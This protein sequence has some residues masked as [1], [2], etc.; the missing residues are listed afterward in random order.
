MGQF[1]ENVLNIN[2]LYILSF[3]SLKK[4]PLNAPLLRHMMFNA[5]ALYSATRVSAMYILAH[6]LASLVAL[7]LLS[8]MLIEIT[9]AG[10]IVLLQDNPCRRFLCLIRAYDR[11][12]PSSICRM[13]SR[14][15][16]CSTAHCA[17]SSTLPR[18][19]PSE[20]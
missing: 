1:Y 9:H 3:R 7:W 18:S 20:V 13:I 2:I 10:Q 17:T 5:S 4:A 14:K 15:N 6:P 11:K 16:A 12:K 19:T 8:G